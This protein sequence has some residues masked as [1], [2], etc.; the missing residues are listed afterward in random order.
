MRTVVDM[1]H[2]EYRITGLPDRFN[3]LLQ[4]SPVA[5]PWQLWLSRS[6][7]ELVLNIAMSTVTPL[8]EYEQ[9]GGMPPVDLAMRHASL[10]VFIDPMVPNGAVEFRD[11]DGVL[12]ARVEL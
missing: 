9:G 7:W 3:E 2:D 4:A 10:P 5:R 6:T 1:G 11:A 12:L 8:F